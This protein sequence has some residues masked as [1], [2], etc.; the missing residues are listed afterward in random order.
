[1]VT[2][3]NNDI[4]FT[5]EM[6]SA[7]EI[8]IAF[9]RTLDQLNARWGTH[10]YGMAIQ[11][12]KTKLVL[13]ALKTR[14]YNMRLICIYMLISVAMVCSACSSLDPSGAKVTKYGPQ[15]VIQ[16]PVDEPDLVSL[17]T[18]GTSSFPVSQSAS[19]E[20]FSKALDKALLEFYTSTATDDDKKLKRNRIQD[21]LIL[22]SNEGCEAFKTVLKRKQGQRNFEFG[23]ATVLFGAAG[24]VASGVTAAKNLAALAGASGGIRAEYNRDFFSD[25]AAHVISKGI[26]SR[27]REILD[28]ITKGQEKALSA[29]S[30]EAAMADLVVYHGACSLVGGLEFA[31][32]AIS[33][34]DNT[35]VGLDALKAISGAIVTKTK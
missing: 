14:E 27:R 4:Q 10:I 28:G 19:A 25:V 24:A 3:N 6:I 26:N 12:K 15:S 23:T 9:A 5:F 31:E 16:Q 17:I 21:R 8:A 22:A 13:T 2:S 1:M 7:P 30:L 32:G 35:Q 33:K 29:Y 11:I 18:G 20:D 34:L